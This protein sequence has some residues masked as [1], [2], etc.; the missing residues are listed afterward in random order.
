MIATLRKFPLVFLLLLTATQLEAQDPEFKWAD[1]PLQADNSAARNIVR[2]AAGNMY[3]TGEQSSGARQLFIAKYSENG[4]LVWN[5]T[6]ERTGE[7][8]SISPNGI[9]L[10]AAGDLFVVGSFSRTFDF[11]PGPEVDE[12]SGDVGK[13]FVLKLNSQGEYLWAKDYFPSSNTDTW[14]ETEE[15]YA[16]NLNSSGDLLIATWRRA[17]DN[18]QYEML[19]GR[20]ALS[21]IN[22]NSGAVS[23]TREISQESGMLGWRSVDGNPTG[24]PFGS[25]TIDKWGNTYIWGNFEGT[26]DLYP[27]TGTHHI[28]A[29]ATHNE[30]LVKWDASGNF[31]WG[32]LL[33]KTERVTRFSLKTDPWGNLYRVGHFG[34]TVDFDPG[35][36]TFELT[37]LNQ[38]SGGT[39]DFEANLF[40][41]KHNVTGDFLWAKQVGG[42]NAGIYLQVV[43]GAKFPA[44]DPFGNVHIWGS[45]SGTV[46]FDPGDGVFEM[47]PTADGNNFWL[48]LDRDGNFQWVKRTGYAMYDLNIDP[49]GDVHL[50]GYFDRTAEMNLGEGVS[51]PFV[52]PSPSNY[53]GL[54]AKY[55]VQGTNCPSGDIVLNSQELVDNF[56][57]NYPGCMHLGGGLKITAW[58]NSLSGLSP[59]KSIGGSFEIDQGYF[60]TSLT[61]LENVTSVAG[62]IHINVGGAP[63]LNSL[64]GFENLT[65]VGGEVYV[66]NGS[67]LTSLTGL[68]NLT[69]IGTN[70]KIQNNNTLTSLT[71]LQSLTSVGKDISINSSTDLNSLA[72]LDNLA[73]VGGVLSLRNTSLSSLTGL[74]RLIAVRQLFLMDNSSLTSLVGLEMLR[75]NTVLS[76][77]DNSSLSSLTGLENVTSLGGLHIGNNSA[78]VSLAGIENV[79]SV[80]GPISIYLNDGL[81][82]L[83]GLGN[84]TSVGGDIFIDRNTDLNSL[85][86]LENL[87]SIGGQL[88]INNNNTLTTLD[89]LGGRAASTPPSDRVSASLTLTNLTITNNPQLTSCAV[90]LV[91]DHLLVEGPTTIANNGPDG[92][93]NTAE[94]ILVDW[95]SALPVTL[96]TFTGRYTEG[97]AQLNWATTD[98]VSFSRFEIEKSADGLNFI[99]AGSIPAKGSDSRYRHSLPQPE[100]LAYYRLKMIDLDGTFGYSH[101]VS[102]RHD[103]MP[104][105]KV[106]PNPVVGR[107]F[108]EGPGGGQALSIS[109]I[110]MNGRSWYRGVYDALKGIEM[111][112]KPAGLYLVKVVG[113]DG[114]QRVYRVIKSGK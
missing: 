55:R 61:G 25:A 51:Q 49:S 85:T 72:G 65:S 68:E 90:K 19:S 50:G 105:V 8:G 93:C 92:N 74:N 44:I 47:Q 46:D 41:V 63:N 62:D 48:K 2:D 94:A 17:R 107:L 15:I 112:D 87:E 95:E 45:F 114:A 82:S 23:W 71:G 64:I 3:V 109:V 106:F 21:L 56:A 96:T 29:T 99:N 80:T 1:I 103:N 36:G 60:L 31:V 83:T 37:A 77:H 5:K 69:S 4:D 66:R 101:L 38:T 110:D 57:A 98:E 10:N 20:C 40:I 67:A 113:E 30:F 12:L 34:G 53:R 9:V 52:H 89:G 91:V 108:V 7:S 28:T 97:Q 16:L 33:E 84:L 73:S 14:L 70:L 58:T 78:L 76:L 24:F 88:Y 32:R 22:R 81:I 59:L 26:I 104:E 86:G 6:V 102:V 27:G 39:A 111:G 79:K 18:N 75:S 43:A 35:P 11:D 100:A 13:L 42:A 54:V